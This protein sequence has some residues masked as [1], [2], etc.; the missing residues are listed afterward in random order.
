MSNNVTFHW[1]EPCEVGLRN[2]GKTAQE[3]VVQVGQVGLADN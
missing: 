2:L 1:Q 3:G